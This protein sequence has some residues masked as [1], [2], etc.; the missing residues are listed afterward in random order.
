MPRRADL[1]QI[2][3]GIF[4]P[5]SILTV[6][7][8]CF[9]VHFHW[10]LIDRDLLKVDTQHIQRQCK[11]HVKFM[12]KKSFN[13]PFEFLLYKTNGLHFSLTLYR[14]RSRKTSQHVK[15][16]SQHRLCLVLYFLFFT[17]CDVICHL[18]QYTH[19]EKWYLFVKQRRITS[20][21]VV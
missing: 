17:R 9:C 5:T 10:L 6:F 7:E 18:L 20:Y 13:K 16:N 1:G 4:L 15:N 8:G 3:V 19:T 14:N 12:P 11:I 21:N 2:Q